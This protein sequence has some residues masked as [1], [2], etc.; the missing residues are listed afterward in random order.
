MSKPILSIIIPIYNEEKMVAASLPAIFNLPLEKDIIVINDGSVDN[1]LI[2]L[3]ELQQKYKFQLINQPTNQGKGAAVRKGLKSILSDYFIV[4]DADLEYN[5][6]EI[7]KLLN[8]KQKE[9]DN[10][11]IVYGSRF[12][13]HKPKTIHYLVNHCLTGLTNLLFHS[14]LTDMETCFKL[15]PSSA[16]DKIKLSGKRFE[17]EPEITAQLL[18][19]GYKIKELA[20]SYH[21]RSYRDGKK[22]T[23]K[24]GLLAIITLFREKWINK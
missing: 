21:H 19:K 17:I 1:T 7:I 24:D 16:L 9:D 10:D 12:L 18:K 5:P 20:I 22:I 8:F 15:I 13:E 3:R 4:C 6:Q 2:I 11:L 14:Q 23:P